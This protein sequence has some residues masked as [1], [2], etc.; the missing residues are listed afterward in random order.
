MFRESDEGRLV[1][2]PTHDT[3]FREVF[4]VYE[5]AIRAYCLRRLPAS[6][7][8]DAVAETFL[9]VWRKRHE[10]PTGDEQRLW[11]YGIARNVVRN[12]RRSARRSQRLTRRVAREPRAHQESPEVIVVRNAAETELLAAIGQLR[13]V[14]REIL[15]LRT[16]EGLSSCEIATVMHLTTKAVDN[17][18]AR[19]RKKLTRMITVPAVVVFP[20]D[21]RPVPEGGE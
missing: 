10:A 21:P 8:D 15:L 13:A 3:A 11:L 1:S 18:L 16:W 14:E 20:P 12:A 9:A 6:Q 2:S 7:A 19:I 17:R 5:P 4:D